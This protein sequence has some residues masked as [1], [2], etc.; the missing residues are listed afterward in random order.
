M[1]KAIFI[2]AIILI[3]LGKILDFFPQFAMLHLGKLALGAAAVYLLFFE[4]SAFWR[5][6]R[7]NALAPYLAA[8]ALLATFGVPFSVWRG[9]AW[10]GL[11]GY[12]K[13]LCIFIAVCALAQG[14]QASVARHAAIVAMGLLG[15]M[16]IAA[17]GA[18]GAEGL[19]Q[20]LHVS[21]TYDPNDIAL[22]FVT[23]LPLAVA[24]ALIGGKMMRV[25]GLG[26]ACAAVVGI[27]LTQ[28]RG[29]VASL[30]LVA[31]HALLMA[32]RR[33]WLLLPILL[34][35]AWI[36]F[37]N[38]DVRIW[39]RFQD[40]G[41]QSD[42]NFTDRAGRLEVWREGLMLM[43]GH[44]LLGV[45]VGQ[46]ANAL[47]MV[48]SG[49]YITAH[50]TYIQIG[51]ELGVAG[52]VLY[53]AMLWRLRK[54]AVN[55]IKS[56]NSGDRMRSRGML[57]ALTGFAAGSFL[58]S[59]AYSPILYSLLALAALAHME[60]QRHAEAENAA[61]KKSAMRGADAAPITGRAATGRNTKVFRTSY[62]AAR[63]HASGGSSLLASCAARRAQKKLLL[64]LGD[65]RRSRQA[66]ISDDKEQK[67]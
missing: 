33:A 25:V 15:T 44:P 17:R 34:V 10:E 50:N 30:A 51:A 20:R 13:T 45:G 18:E 9:G 47:G 65:I 37:N 41:E 31:G 32:G 11:I 7:G 56:P 64:E 42:Y 26:S 28:S 38:A 43:A 12:M 63:K 62:S 2:Y 22:F 14:G 61:A 27:A 4:P 48:G 23:F 16:I 6:L 52:L 59:L 29:G 35:G 21:G 24:E 53:L 3:N 39:E 40:L 57:L 46:F 1:V 58:L 19:M 5:A 49:V 54:I 67:P 8:L 66:P 55:G 36:F 60:R